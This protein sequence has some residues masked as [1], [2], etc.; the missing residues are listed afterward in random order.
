VQ[1]PAEFQLWA[2]DG[3]A[4]DLR[5]W[6]TKFSGTLRDERWLKPV[7]QIYQRYAKWEKYLRN[8]RPL[9]RVAV[10]YSQ[11]TGWF[12]GGKIEDHINGWYQA[13]I[14]A[15]VPFEM[16]HDRLLDPERLAPFKTLILPNLAALSDQQCDQLRA[17]V[18]SGGSLIATHET[19]LCDEWGVKR[20]NFGLAERFGVNFA[21]RI[22]AR[23][24]NAYLRLEH[25]AAPR[26]PL[27]RGLEDAPRIIH[28][29]ARVEVTPREEFPAPPLTLIPSYPDLPMEKVFPRVPKTNIA[30][31]FLREIGN[32]RVAYFPWDIDRTFWEVL[33]VDHFK[34]LRNAVEWAT[35]EPPIIEVIGAGVLDVTVWQQKTSMTVHLVNLTNP[36]M[37]KGPIREFIPVGEQQVTVRLP[38]GTK[39][40]GA[41]LLAS[42]TPVR[43]EKNGEYF[44][45]TV[46]SILDHEI[47]AINLEAR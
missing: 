10:V 4:N 20:T 30:Q 32:G 37:M 22:E 19:S 1:N 27:L 6:F 16:V 34:L 36:M 9:A 39:A 17:F 40:T 47:I 45:L 28:G 23:M 41:H 14:E 3:V 26:H 18:Q 42:G 31:V 8:E 43:V 15:R 24:Q 46:P 35:N 33:C 25:E 12:Y 21:G 44:G 29:V 5:P 38:T 13:L 11:Q 2:A 7:E